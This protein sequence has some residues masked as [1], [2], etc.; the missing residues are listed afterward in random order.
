MKKIPVISLCTLLL[1]L[2]LVIGE[3]VCFCSDTGDG[4]PDIR[5]CVSLLNDFTSSDASRIRS[6]A[7][8]GF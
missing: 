8:V 3:D 7:A 5:D 1:L 4:A 6:G 2:R